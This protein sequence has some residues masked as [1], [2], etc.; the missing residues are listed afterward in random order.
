M[1]SGK[2]NNVDYEEFFERF[3][4]E[5]GDI[6]WELD[7]DGTVRCMAFLSYKMINAFKR[8]NALKAI[9]AIKRF[10]LIGKV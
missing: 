6:E 1:P 2:D 7:P 8:Q 10:S 9:F 3:E 4:H 5:G